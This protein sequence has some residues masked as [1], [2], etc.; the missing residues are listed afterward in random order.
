M[1]SRD[2]HHARGSTPASYLSILAVIM[3][4]IA[5][6]LSLWRDPSPTAPPSA[7]LTPAAAVSAIPAPATGPAP[8]VGA[9]RS[10]RTAVE[11]A[12]PSVVNVYTAKRV[13][14]S[15]RRYEN[16]LFRYF[17][18][19]AEPEEPSTALGS[20]VIVSAEG[21]IL[22][23]NHVVE[24]AD[25]I[26]V[27]L[28]DGRIA[29]ARVVGT[30]PE[31]DLA[32]LKINVEGLRPIT[33]AEAASLRVGDVVLAIGNPFGV[34]QT[35][36]QGIVSATGR[37]RLG[38]NVFEN[39]IQTDAAINPGNSGGA[40]VDVDGNLVG[41]NT[42]MFSQSGGSQGI[43]FAI[44]LGLGLQVMKSIVE[45]GRVVRGWLGVEARDATGAESKG[46]LGAQIA[47][48]QRGSPAARAGLRAGDIVVSVNGDA[49]PDAS[50]LMLKAAALP[51]K[52]TG[53]LKVL[54]E[55]REMLAK[56]EIGERPPLRR[57]K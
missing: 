2:T 50:A 37:T 24:G 7:P 12:A 23:N 46:V 3:A 47:A 26:A 28:T 6:G 10:Y 42:A 41:I 38:I 25:Q 53:E 17:Y 5:I 57:P 39:F 9:A 14:R 43:G 20:G 13:P 29:Q 34:G 15:A 35:V 8:S 36:T 55:G 54:R 52:S 22:T 16:P 33:V 27:A 21:Y 11:K 19:E 49:I 18:G 31:S 30:D 1:I 40:L 32:V 4:S 56:V 51:P 48:V 45:N 44:P